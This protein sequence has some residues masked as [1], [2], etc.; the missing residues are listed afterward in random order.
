LR[1]VYT[2]V[3]VPMVAIDGEDVPRPRLR[4]EV[5]VGDN[6]TEQ[7]WVRQSGSG[8]SVLNVL[9]GEELGADVWDDPGDG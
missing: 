6:Y 4:A 8:D 9:L 5:E 3:Q 7:V 1:V 2:L